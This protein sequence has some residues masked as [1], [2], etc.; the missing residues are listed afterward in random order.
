MLR[1]LQDAI[2]QANLKYRAT[3]VFTF[4][5]I[6][7]GSTYLV[8]GLFISML[9]LKLLLAAGIGSLPIMWINRVRSRR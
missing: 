7:G 2:E 5:L 8:V 4:S 6:I 9:F 1:R 3:E